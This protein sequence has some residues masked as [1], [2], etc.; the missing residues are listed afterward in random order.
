MSPLNGQI[1][2]NIL[3]EQELSMKLPELE[4]DPN[5]NV[6]TAP[7]LFLFGGQTGMIQHRNRTSA[8]DNFTASFRSTAR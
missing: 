2:G 1:R 6:L 5:V 3:S 4:N 7:S 8:I